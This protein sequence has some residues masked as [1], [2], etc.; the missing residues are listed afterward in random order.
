MAYHSTS[1]PPPLQHPVPT[2]PPYIPEPP[3]TPGTPASPQGYMRFTSS[4]PVNPNQNT[5]PLHVHPAAHTQTYGQAPYATATNHY[6]SFAANPPPNAGASG[7]IP[8]QNYAAQWGV[9]GATAQLGMQLGQSAV[10]AGQDYV[11]KNVCTCSSPNYSPPVFTSSL[12]TLVLLKNYSLVASYLCW[13]LSTILMCRIHM[14]YA[15]L[16]SSSFHGGT[17]P[18]RAVFAALK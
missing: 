6:Q 1:S 9:D 8:I 14:C 17:A 3:S 10:A 2:H 16:A 15:N 5:Q 11:Q 4:P 12:R 18:G 13:F 7:P